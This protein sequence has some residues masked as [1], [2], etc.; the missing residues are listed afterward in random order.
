MSSH[1]YNKGETLPDGAYDYLDRSGLEHQI[2]RSRSDLQTVRSERVAAK[3]RG[4]IR[5]GH[6]S[7]VPGADQ[8]R[9]DEWQRKLEY[10]DSKIHYIEREIQVAERALNRL[11]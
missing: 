7:M 8:R 11:R 5:D 4:P 2:A 6:E 10:F 3:E 1:L 9:V